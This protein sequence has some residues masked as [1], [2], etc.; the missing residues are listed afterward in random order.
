MFTVVRTRRTVDS[1]HDIDTSEDIMRWT[2]GVRQVG[3]PPSQ[4]VHLPLAQEI[5]GVRE[6]FVGGPLAGEWVVQADSR[7]TGG[8]RC[9]GGPRSRRGGAPNSLT[10]RAEAAPHLLAASARPSCRFV[11]SS[12]SLA[13]PREPCLLAGPVLLRPLRKRVFA[14]V[15]L[16]RGRP[17]AAASGGGS[18]RGCSCRRRRRATCGE[19]AKVGNGAPPSSLSPRWHPVEPRPHRSAVI[20]PFA[21]VAL[22][23]RLAFNPCRR[24]SLPVIHESSPLI[25]NPLVSPNRKQAFHHEIVATH[26]LGRG[27]RA[28]DFGISPDKS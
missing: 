18:M 27:A 20:A 7:T 4:G 23:F 16:S 21:A 6:L 5:P 13:T 24:V 17:L 15:S 25:H 1:C 22:L 11:F 14:H 3:P 10:Q 9:G 12:I 2:S 8:R 28:D 19:Q 26:L